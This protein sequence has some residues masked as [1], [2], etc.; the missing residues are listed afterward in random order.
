[1]VHLHE[2]EH[3]AV[4]MIEGYRIAI[5]HT[6]KARNE[7]DMGKD[8]HLLGLLANFATVAG[9]QAENVTPSMGSSIGVEEID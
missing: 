7:V 5:S 8:P 1:M 3:L 2:E 6:L 4:S 9:R